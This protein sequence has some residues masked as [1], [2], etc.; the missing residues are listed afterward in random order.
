MI[1]IILKPN[2]G[3]DNTVSLC[4]HFFNMIRISMGN[5]IVWSDV[6]HGKSYQLILHLYYKIITDPLHFS[7]NIASYWPFSNLSV[8]IQGLWLTGKDPEFICLTIALSVNSLIYKPHDHVDP[9]PRADQHFY[10]TMWEV[11]KINVCRY[12]KMKIPLASQPI[13]LQEF[14]I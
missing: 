5:N 3:F 4:P 7:H 6:F 13:R 9:P 1:L 14:L 8:L 12:S 11:W 10:T 2:K